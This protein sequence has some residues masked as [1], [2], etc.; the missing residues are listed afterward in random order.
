MFQ[1]DFTILKTKYK[2]INCLQNQ[3]MNHFKVKHIKLLLKNGYFNGA[4]TCS[5]SVLV[6]RNEFRDY[7]STQFSLP[8]SFRLEGVTPYIR[9]DT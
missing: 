7:S 8:V 5:L 9:S 4:E 3:L 6:S 2:F 1:K